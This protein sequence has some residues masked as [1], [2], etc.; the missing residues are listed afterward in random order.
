MARGREEV[1][2]RGGGDGERKGG[3]EMEEWRE[4]E[5][6]RRKNVRAK[7]SRSEAPTGGNASVAV[8]GQ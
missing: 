2:R 6:R 4:G 1:E 5:K 7:G 3:R 8:C